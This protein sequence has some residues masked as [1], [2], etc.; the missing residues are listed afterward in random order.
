M[1]VIAVRFKIKQEYFEKFSARVR[2]QAQ[3]TLMAEK[4][5]HRFEVSSG[6]QN[7]GGIFLYEIY[8]DESAFQ[9]HLSSP[10]FVSFKADTHDW[11]ESSVIERWNG[12]WD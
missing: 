12:P 3:D 8:T 11:V 7:T 1:L 9:L 2:R 5:C 10:H 6:L 4:D